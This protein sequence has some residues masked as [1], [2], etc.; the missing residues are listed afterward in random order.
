MA[1]PAT[2]GGPIGRG[3]IQAKLEEIKGEVDT[4]TDSAKPYLL[5]AGIAAG[6]LV[7]TAAY[8]LGR[9]RGKKKTTV[10]EIRRV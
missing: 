10:V 8:L 9:R 4:T 2:P 3:D 5:A 6:V 1:K 7:I